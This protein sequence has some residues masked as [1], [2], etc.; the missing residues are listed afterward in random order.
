MTKRGQ[1][2][3]DR[4]AHATGSCRCRKTEYTT[5]KVAVSMAKAAEKRDEGQHRV[6]ACPTKG[7]TWHITHKARAGDEDEVLE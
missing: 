6:Y 2:V 4:V 1:A 3:A 7:R 5:V